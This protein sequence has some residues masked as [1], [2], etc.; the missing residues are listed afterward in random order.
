MLS[1]APAMIGLVEEG[2][3]VGWL[4]YQRA[5][6]PAAAAPAS[7]PLKRNAL[8]SLSAIDMFVRLQNKWEWVAG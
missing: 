4:L 6:V 3:G 2:E 8:V 5:N 7:N 1:A